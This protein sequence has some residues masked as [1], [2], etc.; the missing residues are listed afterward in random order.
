M[1]HIAIIGCGYV[2]LC[3]A[4]LLT[5]KGH[6]VTAT[7]RNPNR[8][9]EL[10]QVA[11]KS[12]LLKGNHEEEFIPLIAHQEVLIVTIAADSPEFY[13]SAYLHTAQMMRHLA[14]EMN[15]PRHLIYTSSTSVYGEYNGQWVDENYEL[16]AKGEQAR[17]LI[18]TEK[19]YLSLQELGWH[20]CILR[21][22]E[23]YG[24]GRELSKRVENLEG[25]SLPGNG[26]GF[27][28]MIHRTDCGS[29]IDYAIKHHLEGVF[30]LA[31]DDHPT[32]KELYE[33]IAQKFDLPPVEWDPSRAGMHST[34]KR[35]SNHKIKSEGFVF[36]HPHRILD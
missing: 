7:T 13:E 23:I 16:L 10:S 4:S 3:V 36:R 2:G 15:L 29:A 17:I 27:T 22:A 9:E 11:Q 31:D 25:H 30:N 19:T 34:N 6:S 8:L 33:Q 12:L 5:K 18:E 32:R 14:L 21:L 24:P 28:N 1:K 26:E 20:V 35:I